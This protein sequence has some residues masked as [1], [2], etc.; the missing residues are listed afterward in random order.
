MAINFKNN[1]FVDRRTYDKKGK[2][3]NPRDDIEHTI[4][5]FIKE[6]LTLVPTISENG[7]EE[8]VEQITITM[9]GGK[10]IIKGDSI[11]LATGV[12]YK[13]E[14]IVIN[15]IENNVLVADLLKPRIESMEL[16]L[17]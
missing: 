6:P 14:D 17:R 8:V 7:Q 3:L 4:F 1:S 11:V 12:K 2:W 13:V 10:Q 9:F 16:V 15:Y 5:Y